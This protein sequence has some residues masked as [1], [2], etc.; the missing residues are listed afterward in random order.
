MSYRGKVLHGGRVGAS[1][2][3]FIPI[4]YVCLFNQLTNIKLLRS[5]AFFYFFFFKSRTPRARISV[6]TLLLTF[7]RLPTGQVDLRR[8][9]RHKVVTTIAYGWEKDYAITHD[10]DVNVSKKTKANK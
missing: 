9:R 4:V 2:Q 8:Q 3:N 1:F 7:L 6:Q 10:S 5:V